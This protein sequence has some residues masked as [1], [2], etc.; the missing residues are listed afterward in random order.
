MQNNLGMVSQ[1]PSPGGRCQKS[2]A[3]AIGPAAAS[4][5]VLT[6][7]AD[8]EKDQRTRS[9]GK[10]IAAPTSRRTIERRPSAARPLCESIVLRL[11][12]GAVCFL[13]DL[14][15]WSSLYLS[16]CLRHVSVLWL[17]LPLDL[18][19]MPTTLDIF[20]LGR[21]SVKPCLSCSA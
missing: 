5:T 15:L 16:L 21:V 8:T 13:S 1:R 10:H 3:S 20:F 2:S 17:M 12:G 18:W 4:D 6:H 19:P 9:E 7:G 11:V 14:A